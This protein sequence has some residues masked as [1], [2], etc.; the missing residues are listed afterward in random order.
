MG[1]AP[2]RGR[3]PVG[4]NLAYDAPRVEPH[5]FAKFQLSRSDG[6]GAYSEHTNIHTYTHTHCQIYIRCPVKMISA[7]LLKLVFLNKTSTN[8]MTDL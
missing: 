6:A 2:P 3:G 8:L 1:P 4:P 5:L 7:K